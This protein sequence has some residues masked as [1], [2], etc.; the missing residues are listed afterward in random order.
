MTKKS[1]VKKYLKNKIDFQNLKTEWQNSWL[2]DKPKSWLLSNGL[3][4]KYCNH[5]LMAQAIEQAEYKN[6]HSDRTWQT[7]EDVRNELI[8]EIVF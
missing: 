2:K 3:A 6:K 8:M 5:D 1:V 7:V 4:S